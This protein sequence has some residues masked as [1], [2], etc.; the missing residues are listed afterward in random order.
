MLYSQEVFRKATTYVFNFNIGS[1]RRVNLGSIGAVREKMQ[2]CVFEMQKYAFEMGLIWHYWARMYYLL[3]ESWSLLW[4]AKK[5]RGFETL[6]AR[7]NSNTNKFGI[8][9]TTTA[10]STAKKKNIAKEQDEFCSVKSIFTQLQ[11]FTCK[12]CLI[13]LIIRHELSERNILLFR[14]FDNKSQFLLWS[15][16]Y[17]EAQ[18]SLKKFNK[19]E[20][21]SE[22]EEEEGAVCADV[23]VVGV[24]NGGGGGSGKGDDDDC[25]DGSVNVSWRV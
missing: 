5:G 19:W 24:R 23:S 9:S 20:R 10:N 22:E 1:Y 4:W 15:Q 17:Y 16:P 18:A 21:I 12:I 6:L 7:H 11:N 2:K 3:G 14:M 25:G 8:C 13:K